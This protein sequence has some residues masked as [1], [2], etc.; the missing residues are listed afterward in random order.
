M[1]AQFADLRALAT[2]VSLRLRAAISHA[3]SS[4][5]GGALRSRDAPTIVRLY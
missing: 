4:L 1:Q 3:Q 2:L 5:A